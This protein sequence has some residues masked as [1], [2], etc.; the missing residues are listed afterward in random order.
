MLLYSI[1]CFSLFFEVVF[2]RFLPILFLL[3]VLNGKEG[4]SVRS[5]SMLNKETKTEVTKAEYK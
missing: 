1:L 4:K 3:L 2:F 5:L